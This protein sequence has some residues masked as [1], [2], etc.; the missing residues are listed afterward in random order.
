MAVTVSSD[1]VASLIYDPSRGSSPSR[2]FP[3]IC[4]AT[5][6]QI[7]TLSGFPLSELFPSEDR[8]SFKVLP[9]LLFTLF[10]PKVSLRSVPEVCP[11]QKVV[12]PCQKYFI[13]N[14]DT[15]SLSVSTF[16]V[17]SPFKATPHFCVPSLNG[18]PDNSLRSCTFT[19]SGVSSLK[20]LGFSLSG[21]LLS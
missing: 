19:H 9:L 15:G 7:A 18:Y 11:L 6:F 1:K 2:T 17:F 4:P 13:L 20:G 14:P 21:S 3:S 5:I 8:Y 10:H 16:K 12:H